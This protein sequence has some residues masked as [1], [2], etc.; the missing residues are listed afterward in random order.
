MLWAVIYHHP[1]RNINAFQSKLC[2]LL[3]ELEAKKNHYLICGDINTNA[4]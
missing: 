3:K 4:L 2:D 1:N